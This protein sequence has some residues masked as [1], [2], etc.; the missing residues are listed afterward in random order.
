MLAGWLA[1]WLADVACLRRCGAAYRAVKSGVWRKL[2]GTL[3]CGG[4]GLTVRNCIV[5]IE[6]TLQ[7]RG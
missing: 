4:I 3:E 5:Y 2:G 7:A 6:E 1:G